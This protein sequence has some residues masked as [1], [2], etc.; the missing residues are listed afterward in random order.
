V[1]ARRQTRRG[2]LLARKARLLAVWGEFDSRTQQLIERRFAAVCRAL[3]R[4][5]ENQR[6]REGARDRIKVGT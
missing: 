1:A 3:A 6:A 5:D 4:V 2:L